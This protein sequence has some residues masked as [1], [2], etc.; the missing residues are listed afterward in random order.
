LKLLRSRITPCLLLSNKGLVKTT[1]F[2]KPQY[3]GDPL[4]AVKIFNEKAVDE[5]VF[6]DID[7]SRENRDPNYEL[8]RRIAVECRMP[9]CYGGGVTS[10]AQ[11]ERIIGLGVE[12]VAISSA[13]I[14]DESLI[15][16]VA[17]AVG[18][19][20]VCVVIDVR[21]DARSKRYTAYVLNGEKK[22]D[23]DPLVFAQRAQDLGTGEIVVNSIDRDGVMG[24]YD[25][26]L[27]KAFR[28]VTNIPLTFLGGAGSTDHFQELIDAIGVCG[29]AAGSY[30]VFKGKF[31]AVLISYSRPERL[32]SSI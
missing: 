29:A 2:G 30:F 26:E 18:R 20:S 17:N 4:N 12:K 27:A 22:V 23:I 24:G 8:I 7:A 14:V 9:L 1:N 31:R 19:Q 11:A 16:N 5:L 10:A 32:C 21:K 3:V 13:A 6:L 28:E 15:A 25:L